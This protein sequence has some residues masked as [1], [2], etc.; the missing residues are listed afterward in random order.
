[1]NL[2]SWTR[3]QLLLQLAATGVLPR[4][5]LLRE[6]AAQSPATS[7][8]P[9]VTSGKIQPLL[10]GET[11]R[12]LRYSPSPQGF[13]IHNGTEYF[14]RPL[15]SST[16]FRVDAGDLPEFSLYLPG[17]GGN[18]K[19]GMVTAAGSKWASGA[20]NILARYEG[21]RMLYEIR[22]SL[23]G[24]GVLHLEV[25]TS[26]DTT[27]L[28]V[29]AHVSN[30]H[31]GLSLAWAFGG[32][33]GRK[34][35]RGGD[36]GCESEPVSELFQVREAD[37]ANNHFSISTS[38]A[39][40]A[41]LTSPAG[42]FHLNF[43]A[44][45]TITIA[46]YQ[47]WL[48]PPRVLAT[49]PTE[50]L[51][52]P[53]LIATTPLRNEPLYLEVHQDTPAAAV[54][55]R[56]PEASYANAVSLFE[57]A[58]SRLTVS[59]PDA[60][61]N[62]AAAALCS[63][64]TGI[65]DEKQ[66]C[67]MHGAIAWRSPLAGW[68][69]P[70]VLDILGE[71]EK[72]KTHFRHWFARQ[73][74]SPIT[75]ANP[76]TGPFDPGKNLSRKESLLHSSGDLSHNHYDMNLVFFDV[77]LRHLRWTG[78]VEFARE[79][80]PAYQRHLDWE[81]RLF[82]REFNVNGTS[83]PL[84]EAYAAIWASDNLQYSGGGTAHATAYNAF[85]FHRAAELA[86]ALG[87][88]PTSFNREA[89]DIDEAIQKLLWIPHKGELAE[90]KDLMQPQTL[91]DNGALWTLY[92]AID[93]EAINRRQAW[94]MTVNRLQ[95][96]RRVPIEGEG[97]PAG[98]W[99]L[100]SC[101]NWLPY[102]WSLNLLLMAENSHLALA[103]WQIG[104]KDEAFR[105]FKGNLLDSMFQGLCPGNFH[106]TSQLDV[107]RQ[108][109]QRDF[110]DPMG[111]TARALLEG[112]YGVR[113]NLLQGHVTWMPG[114]PDDWNE[115]SMTQRDFSLSWQRTAFTERYSFTCRFR[116][117]VTV[118]FV[119][120]ARTTLRPHITALG[121]HVP[122]SFDNDAIGA[123]WLCFEV[124]QGLAPH[125]EIR[126]IGQPPIAAP[127][128]RSYQLGEPLDLPRGITWQQIDD[129]QQCLQDGR[130]A[131]L[132]VRTIFARMATDDARWT[133]PICFTV[134]EPASRDMPYLPA[135]K[136]KLSCVDLSAVLTDNI[137]TIF[138]RRY[139]S[140]RSPF[141][142]LAIPDTLL[143]GWAD[144]GE[145]LE[146]DDWG[147][148]KSDTLTVAGT[149]PF[150]MQP[151]GN[152]NCVFLSRFELD[153]AT[154]RLPLS[155]FAHGIFVLLTGTTLP[156]CSRMVHATM[157][158]Y[159]KDGTQEILQ[160]RN[161]ETWWPVEQDYLFDDYLFCSDAPLPPRVDLATGATRLLDRKSFKGKGRSVK[162]GSA[163][164][165]HLSLDASK[166]LAQVEFTVHLYGVVFALLGVTLERM[167]DQL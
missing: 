144:I 81:R 18:L 32:A 27:S 3:R 166:E 98:A 89:Q 112:L 99:Y 115:A 56:T 70:Y 62:A 91:Y 82:R 46:P 19:L 124:P 110:G 139:I 94:Q 77:L 38:P 111:I 136:S 33:S 67:V 73:N 158:V 140:P 42:I 76:A 86:T 154:Q 30:M 95:L 54:A 20:E 2:P 146:I 157:T 167:T 75:T 5:G 74:T 121:H 120:P 58:A 9:E 92:H 123:P 85:S 96:Y 109:A 150:K 129:P 7:L 47:Q 10:Q 51:A 103:M 66:G 122:C 128:H 12:P 50:D 131:T 52:F 39:T 142:S 59:S 25:Q 155:G 24:A 135:P 125:I 118:R 43:P 1:M 57:A 165:L 145:P 130:V 104:M 133:M 162:G 116:K 44:D 41:S 23:L 160:M 88:D 152:P 137:T 153:L 83:L 34:G 105:L 113:P 37:C 97:V 87:E 28:I 84:Y 35:K 80:W 132:G 40:E 149:L 48:R 126:W 60:Y 108:E 119:V 31:E 16:A 64:E 93:S 61:I 78:D 69:G 134:E 71:H 6:L 13:V 14:N 8:P 29:R 127:E 63:A 11:A 151:S 22:D 49:Q 147:L 141:C 106:M 72:A 36:I 4:L 107:H 138:T 164:V 68:R 90:S 21:G 101:S 102:M 156:Q 26:F 114:F 55:A 143:G 100:L 159:Y 148:H 45:T 79:A 17:H 117:P 161:P 53:I 65:W 15:Y 163:T